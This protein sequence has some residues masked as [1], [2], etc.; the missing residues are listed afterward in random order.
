MGD[1]NGV[2]ESEVQMVKMKVD[3]KVEGL[4]EW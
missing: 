2:N 3:K 1:S 4:I